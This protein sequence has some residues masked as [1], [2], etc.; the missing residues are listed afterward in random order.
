MF[1]ANFLS[2]LGLN[3]RR[4]VDKRSRSGSAILVCVSGCLREASGSSGKV[5]DTETGH[6]TT[7]TRASMT[8]RGESTHIFDFFNGKVGVGWHSRFLWLDINDYEQ[9][10]R[11]VSLEQLVNLE[12][13]G[14]Q[15][16]TRM[17]PS[18]QFLSRVDF[19]EHVIHRF[20]VVVIQKP[21]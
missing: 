14:S 10:V 3:D 21:D 2:L 1:D 8:L 9:R 12:I 7:G 11:C 4:R 13:R 20:H 19:L 5:W 16:R 6:S 15:L 17:V 18:D